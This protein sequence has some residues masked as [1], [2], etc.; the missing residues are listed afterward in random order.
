MKL[1]EDIQREVQKAKENEAK[2]VQYFSERA[3]EEENSDEMFLKMGDL[4]SKKLMESNVQ[5]MKIRQAEARVHSSVSNNNEEL[6]QEVDEL[7]R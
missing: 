5:P 4:R 3:K 2:A 6:R 1:L 7:T